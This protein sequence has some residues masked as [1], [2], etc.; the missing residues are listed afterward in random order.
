MS[1]ASE[2]E[3]DPKSVHPSLADDYKDALLTIKKIKL[4]ME[5]T[6]H[7]YN[8]MMR[9]HQ[10]Y[11]DELESFLTLAKVKYTLD[12]ILEPQVSKENQ[13]L[14]EIISDGLK[15]IHGESPGYDSKI[16]STNSFIL[17]SSDTI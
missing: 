13:Q 16:P 14:Q 1:R 10:S 3:F 11:I 5:G 2:I 17:A 12:K 15:G 7:N 6:T 4:K 9:L 8:K